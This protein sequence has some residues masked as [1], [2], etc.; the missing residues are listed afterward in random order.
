MSLKSLLRY[1]TAQSVKPFCHW[2]PGQFY[3]L[4]VPQGY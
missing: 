2:A 1:V 4:R 3:K